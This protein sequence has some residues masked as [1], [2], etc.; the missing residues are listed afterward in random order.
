M[1]AAIGDRVRVRCR[2]HTGEHASF[3]GH[4]GVVRA[5]LRRSLERPGEPTD[6]EVALDPR[7]PNETTPFLVTVRPHELET[8]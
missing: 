5:V 8:P 6:Y 1:I 4:C 2:L 3:T 7:L